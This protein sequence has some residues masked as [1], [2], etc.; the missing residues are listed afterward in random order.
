MTGTTKRWQVPPGSQLLWERWEH[1]A[2]VYHLLSGETHYL[3]ETATI[4]LDRLQNGEQT[5]TSLMEV[6]SDNPDPCKTLAGQILQM[7]DEFERLG[8]VEAKE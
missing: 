5:L 6:F 4:L 2:V 3:N 7:L 8:L 1:E